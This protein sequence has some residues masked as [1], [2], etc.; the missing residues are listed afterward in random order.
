[1]DSNLRELSRQ[2]G[3]T[4]R[5]DGENHHYK[6]KIGRHHH[7]FRGEPGGE[8]DAGEAAGEETHAEGRRQRGG[9]GVWIVLCGLQKRGPLIIAFAKKNTSLLGREVVRPAEG[10]SE[11]LTLKD[12]LNAAGEAE[13]E[14]GEHQDHVWILHFSAFPFS[15]CFVFDVGVLF[16]FVEKGHDKATHD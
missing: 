11:A 9:L 14:Q 1:M 12:A 16:V 4:W 5:K 8:E 13:E 15:F 7:H 6:P 10:K 3:G 2:L